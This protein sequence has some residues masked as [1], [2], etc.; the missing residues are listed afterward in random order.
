[1]VVDYRKLNKVTK[2]AHYPIPKMMDMLNDLHGSTIYTQIDL[3]MGYY[4]ILIHENDIAKTVFTINNETYEFLRMPFGL[5][6]APRTFQRAIN[7][8]LTDLPY[9]KIHL[10]DIFIH[11][12]NKKEHLQH[13][14]T[15]IKRLHEANA[16]INFE[17]SK[18]MQEE[19][20]F[21]GNIISSKG[22]QPDTSR[23][24]TYNNFEPQNKRQLQ[25]LLGYMIWFRPIIKDLSKTSIQLTNKLQNNLKFTWTDFDGQIRKQY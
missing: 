18:F 9:T 13:I 3:N 25:K 17:K 6:N 15:V 23:T 16:S 1:M 4:Q 14:K 24:S 10:D 21:M 2:E 12:T 11:S 19:V 20:V 7:N 8:I 5:S 22:I